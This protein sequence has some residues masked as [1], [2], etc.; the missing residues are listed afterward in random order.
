MSAS[1]QVVKAFHFNP[2]ARRNVAAIALQHDKA[3]P[4]TEGAKDVRTLMPGSAHLQLAV[5]VARQNAALEI[6]TAR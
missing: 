2:F 6:E 5:G 1:E 3:V 4:L